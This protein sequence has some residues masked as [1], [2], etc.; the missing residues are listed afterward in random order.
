DNTD[1]QDYF[2]IGTNPGTWTPVFRVYNNGNA[3]VKGDLTVDGNLIVSGGGGSGIDADTLDGHDSS[4]FADN[5]LSNV[6]DNT[7]L[8]KIK[9]VDGSGS[10]L[11]A[12]LLDGHHADDFVLKSGDA[13]SGDLF[14]SGAVVI[15]SG[16]RRTSGS[17]L[18]LYGPQSSAILSVQDGNGRI[19]LKWNA[20]KG[21]N[22][23]FLVGSENAAMW[24]FDPCFPDADLFKIKFADGSSANAGDSITWQE[25]LKVG[26]T[27]FS[28]LGNKIW[29][30]GN[31]GSG[32][33]L[34]ADT[35]DTFHASQSPTANQI[36]VLD[37]SGNLNVPS[38]VASN[39][40]TKAGSK[41]YS[42]AEVRTVVGNVS[43]PMV[44]LELINSINLKSGV[45]SVEFSRSTTATYIDRYGVLKYAD[46][47]EPRFEKEGLLLEGSSTNLLKWSEDFTQSEWITRGVTVE[48]NAT[49]APDGSN[50]ASKLVETT[51]EGQHWIAFQDYPAE[52]G[53]YY[54][55][56][57]F[58]KAG[59]RNYVSVY[60]LDPEDNYAVIG[61]VNVDLSNGSFE[62]P[63]G[64]G[65]VQKLADGW[66][67]V[68]VVTSATSSSIRFQVGLIETPWI[69]SYIGDGTSGIYIWGAQLEAKPFP[70][71]YIPTQDSAVTRSADIC[72]LP[73]EGNHPSLKAGN[74][75]SVAV[76]FDVFRRDADLQ[77]YIFGSNWTS[78]Y[79]RYNQ[80]RISGLNTIDYFRTS[81]SYM[82][83]SPADE[84]ISSGRLLITVD[85]QELVCGYLNG[86]KRVSQTISLG[87]EGELPTGI[88]IGS[89]D[90]GASPLYGHI[91]RVRIWDKALSDIEASLV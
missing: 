38:V 22:E 77:R 72:R 34:D 21:L 9:N 56:S 27:N 47:D 17:V 41:V 65:K 83:I 28:Y 80:A 76:D 44:D 30:E 54:A 32:S 73:F 35:V 61:R 78:E 4:Y 40:I 52:E 46:I 23:T 70:T 14:T 1:G 55:G 79:D 3:W 18:E 66:Y 64:W 29:H 82:I 86:I 25:I 7:V 42:E 84:T 48:S 13:L 49:T 45:G 58:L 26:I 37:G 90:N 16:T 15:G 63:Q 71:S 12:D 33:G 68:A 6:S 62:V 39:E 53:Q 11:D 19:Q 57:V 50:T 87:N 20:T 8:N 81:P 91:K 51:E 74:E 89:A 69:A 43:S 2:E 67:R 60:L 88:W 85:S 36:P 59:E 75:F 24:E 10:G 5:A 31:D